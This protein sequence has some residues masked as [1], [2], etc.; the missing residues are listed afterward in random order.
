[1][2]KGGG[3][4]LLKNQKW[5]KFCQL[6]ARDGNATNSYCGA[7]YKPRTAASAA[8]CATK[9]LKNADVQARIEELV[10]EARARAERDAIA[11]IREIRERVTEVLRGRSP[12]D[13]K[14]ADVIRA[15]EFLAKVGGSMPEPTVNVT[16]SLSE[17]GQRIQELL[18]GQ[19]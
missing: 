17:K 9:L 11:D 6:Y 14:A 19:D 1:M 8:S 12:L 15:A 2:G 18:R 7:G 5:E 3:K 13:T 4:A 16:L 10:A